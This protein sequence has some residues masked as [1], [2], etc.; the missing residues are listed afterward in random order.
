MG[1]F[2]PSVLSK[3]P[4]DL[5]LTT[6]TSTVR[7]HHSCRF[8]CNNDDYLSYRWQLYF[9]S[10]THF[11]VEWL[12]RPTVARLPCT[13][14][15]GAMPLAGWPFVVNSSCHSKPLWILF[16]ISPNRKSTALI[17]SFACSKLLSS[18]GIATFNHRREGQ[19]E[20]EMIY[21]WKK[22]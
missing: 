21:L 9:V 11:A 13:L 14:A 19:G 10:T 12:F 6:N 16:A 3:V 1:S 17:R 7:Q 15:P 20:G 18:M 8:A 5:P 22:V 2:L 4:V